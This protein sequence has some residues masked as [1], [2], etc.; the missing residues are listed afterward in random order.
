MV[1]PRILIID[2]DPS[3][4]EFLEM[5]LIEEGYVVVAWSTNAPGHND[6]LSNQASQLNLVLL[7]VPGFEKNKV[8]F[9]QRIQ[10]ALKA[11]V[12]IILLTTDLHPE[13]LANISHINGC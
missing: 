11:D 3:T 1:K 2:G 9:I 12:P 4:R 7:D 10:A 8:R 13:S 5:A 6:D